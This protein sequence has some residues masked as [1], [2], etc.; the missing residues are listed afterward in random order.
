MVFGTVAFDIQ[1]DADRISRIYVWPEVLL[2]MAKSGGIYGQK[3]ARG[4]TESGLLFPTRSLLS[5]NLELSPH[6]NQAIV[7][8]YRRGDFT[9][10]EVGAIFQSPAS[11]QGNRIFRLGGPL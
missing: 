1:L 6:E 2:Y 10:E 3:C 5:Y 9:L 4:A 11:R 8:A 7:M